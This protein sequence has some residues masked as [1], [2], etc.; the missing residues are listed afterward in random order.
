VHLRVGYG[1]RAGSPISAASGVVNGAK[2]PGGH[3]VPNGRSHEGWLVNKDACPKAVLCQ[4]RSV[5]RDDQAQVNDEACARAAFIPTHPS[6][7]TTTVDE[8]DGER[9]IEGVHPASQAA[10]DSNI[11]CPSEK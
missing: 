11:L 9:M 5:T 8:H 1:G 2:M 4:V 3:D 6:R 10:K 7:A